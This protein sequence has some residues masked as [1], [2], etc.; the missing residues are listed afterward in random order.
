MK[1]E[2]ISVFERCTMRPKKT[3]YYLIF[4]YFAFLLS[5][6]L[7]LCSILFSINY[8]SFVFSYIITWV[9]YKKNSTL[10]INLV[11]SS[12]ANIYKPKIGLVFFRVCLQNS[13]SLVLASIKAMEC[14]YMVFTTE[15]LLEVAVESWPG[16]DLNP[17]TL[18]SVQTL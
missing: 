8:F 13:V 11:D 10:V 12:V 5:V 9:F 3:K 2:K 15:G 18:N 14:I 4:F 6:Y 16:W 7:S 17:R 1:L